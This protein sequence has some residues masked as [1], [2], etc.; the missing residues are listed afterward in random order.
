[1]FDFCVLCLNFSSNEVFIRGTQFAIFI[2]NCYFWFVVTIS[3]DQLVENPETRKIYGSSDDSTLK[4]SISLLGILEPLIVFKI[5][6]SDQYQIISG[7][8]R[9][10]VA[11]ELGISEVPISIIEEKDIDEN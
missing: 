1:M 2:V 11:K 3:T 9:F 8:R 10:E 7:N 4:L 6:A 5:G